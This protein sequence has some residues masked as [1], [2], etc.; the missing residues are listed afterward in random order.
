M[1]LLSHFDMG[2]HARHLS[3]LIDQD[4]HDLGDWLGGMQG[5]CMSRWQCCLGHGPGP[6]VIR[7]GQAWASACALLAPS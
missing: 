3:A 5:V 7:Q 6:T 2:L 4:G 1:V